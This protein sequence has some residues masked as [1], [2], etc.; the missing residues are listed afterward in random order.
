[1]VLTYY[2]GS[3]YDT[4]S[5]ECATWTHDVS[6]RRTADGMRMWSGFESR[7]FFHDDDD[8]ACGM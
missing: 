1:M 7:S 8:V 2:Y 6:A 3:K 4:L 5:L